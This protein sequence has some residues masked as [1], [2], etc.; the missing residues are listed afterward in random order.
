MIAR[1]DFLKLAGSAGLGLTLNGCASA[2]LGYLV[3]A[4]TEGF[5]ESLEALLFKTQDPVPEFAL[6]RVQP[7]A[8]LVNGFS[9]YAPE[10][11]R[12]T[13][14]LTI[15]GAVAKP[16]SLPLADL[17]NLPRK[18]MVIRHVCV[19]GWAAIV[20]WAGV[21]LREL[22]KM[23]QPDPAV[24][25]VYIQSADGYYESWDIASLLHPQTILAYEMN[26]QSIPISNGAPLRLASPIKLGYKLSKWVTRLT[27]TE[28]LVPPPWLRDR[29]DRA[30]LVATASYGLNPV[31][32]FWEDQGY[33]WFAGL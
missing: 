29:S 12:T 26:G 14:R 16:L 1:R 17:Y 31:K 13:F 10:L 25:Y 24:K 8:L 27:F 7:E 23:A 5:N 19:E 9:R 11:D 20:Q 30:L 32:G 15:D 22:V 18:S 33:E 3:G 4:G 2:D 21:P 28:S 6:S